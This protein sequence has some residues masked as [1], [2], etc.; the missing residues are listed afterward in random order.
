MG[1]V[2]PHRLIVCPCS[3]PPPSPPRFILRW[4]GGASQ[5]FGVS[6]HLLY[7]AAHE[8]RARLLWGW[9]PLS[10]G[11]ESAPPLFSSS[12]HVVR[13]ECTLL[14]GDPLCFSGGL[15]SPPSQHVVR[16]ERTLI[17]RCPILLVL[18]AWGVF[19]LL[20]GHAMRWER[21]LPYSGVPPF[22]WWGPPLQLGSASALNACTVRLLLSLAPV[23]CAPLPIPNSACK[24]PA[25]CGS[26]QS[27]PLSLLPACG[28]HA[29]LGMGRGVFFLGPVSRGGPL[30]V[31][32]MVPPV[33]PLHAVGTR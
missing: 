20:I 21:T 12:Q 25:R 14:G 31:R 2:R 33:R 9:P 32:S 5:V 1:K 22:N 3:H 23:K 30:V 19:L 28:L 6:P 11:M 15:G 26:V 27:V 7:Q 16:W 18:L 10:F 8:G 4:G 24:P 13:W 29:L 17:R